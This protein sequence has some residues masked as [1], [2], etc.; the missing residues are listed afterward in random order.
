MKP[1][2]ESTSAQE[3]HISD[4]NVTIRSA[5][6]LATLAQGFNQ[7]LSGPVVLALLTD[8]QSQALI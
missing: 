2:P 5:G 8:S 1:G 4:K 7:R 3:T 6:F